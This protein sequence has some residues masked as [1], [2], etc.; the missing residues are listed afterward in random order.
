M[1]QLGD[2]TRLSSSTD[3][4]IRRCRVS[5]VLAPVARNASTPV[6][7][8]CR[9]A[10]LRRSLEGHEPVHSGTLRAMSPREKAVPAWRREA[11]GT[12]RSADDRFTIRG[13]GSGRWF[14]LDDEEHDE[15]GLP[16]TIGPLATLDAAKAGAEEQRGR[17][18]QKSPLAGRIKAGGRQPERGASRRSGPPSVSTGA[19]GTRSLSPGK[20]PDTWLDRLEISDPAA[21]KR[22][23]GLIG[24]LEDS[25]IANAVDV[26]RKDVEGQRPAV[27]ESVLAEALRRAIAKTKDPARLLDAVLD[28]IS[29]RER[30]EGAD[31][32]LPGWRLLERGGTR[33]RRVRITSDDVL[34]DA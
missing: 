6:C 33:E 14:L 5:E 4:L 13:E 22:A 26:V 11:A 20:A 31:D 7:P 9:D 17:A 8:M 34:E 21:A 25:G 28:V 3:L 24:A 18:R 15:L 27:A 1:G 19:K 23:R 12:Y 16:R 32:R 10:A 2:E 29:M 30:L